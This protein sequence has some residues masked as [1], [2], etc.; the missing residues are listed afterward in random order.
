MVLTRHAVIAALT[1]AILLVRMAAGA[2][3]A[4]Q[5]AAVSAAEI[6]D[7][8]KQFG[9]GDYRTRDQAEK[10]LTEIG[11]PASGVPCWAPNTNLPILGIVT[12]SSK[13]PT[14]VVGASSS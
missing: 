7:L 2:A 11:Q 8:A 6:T 12:G 10:R 14:V 13:R 4:Q 1:A 5:P 9:S 3:R